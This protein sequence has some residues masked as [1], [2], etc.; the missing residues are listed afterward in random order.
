MASRKPIIVTINGEEHVSH[1]A[2]KASGAMDGFFGKAKGWSTGFANFKAG[3][4]L[5][6]GGVQKFAGAVM[7]TFRAADAFETAQRKLQGTSKLTGISM[8]TL[9]DIAAS[10]KEALKLSTVV[11]NDFASEI[12]K[13]TSKAGDITKSKDAMASFLEIG[14]ARGLSASETLQAVQQAVL[15]IDEGTDKLFGKNP[16]SLYEEYA[17]KVGKSAAKLTDQEKALALVDAAMIGG[18]ATRGS[19][20]SFLDTAA[21]KQDQMNQRIEEAKAQFG[22]ALQPLRLLVMDGIMKLVEWV[23]RPEIAAFAEVIVTIG[24]NLLDS[25]GPAINVLKVV[26]APTL[27]VIMGLLG[28]LSFAVRAYA[29]YWQDSFGKA[30]SSIAGFG[31]SVAGLLKKVGIDVNTEGLDRMKAYGEAQQKEADSRWTALTKEHKEFWGRFRTDAKRG[32]G[33]TLDEVKSASTKQVGAMNERADGV[34]GAAGKITESHKKI[35][36]AA[37]ESSD[38][39]QAAADAYFDKASAKLGKPLALTIGMTEGALRDLS[40]AARE[41]LPPETAEKFAGHMQT[42]A[43]RAE[44][45][46][47]KV[48]AIKTEADGAKGNTKDVADNVKSVAEEALNAAEQFGVVDEAAG[49]SLQSALGIAEAFGRMIANGFT[50]GG[51]VGILGGVA[52]IVG[53]MMQGDRERRELQRESN[54][55]LKD[56]T[57]RVRELTKEVGLLTLDVAGG[58]VASIEAFLEELVPKLARGGSV[59]GGPNSLASIING[60]T[61]QLVGQ[62]LGWDSIVELSK[63]FGINLLDRNGAIDFAQLPALLTALRNTNTAAPAKDFGSQLDILR[64]G[65]AVNSTDDLG[66][67]GQILNLAEQFSPS[68]RGVFRG[69]NLAGTRADLQR[70]FNELAGGRLTEAQLGGLTG[71]QFL[72]LLTDVIGRIDKISPTSATGAES[73]N[74]G[75]PEEA[76]TNPRETTEE[77]AEERAERERRQERKKKLDEIELQTLRAEEAIAVLRRQKMTDEIKKKI[78]HYEAMI[79]SLREEQE[80]WRRRWRIEDITGIHSSFDESEVVDAILPSN[81]GTVTAG[82]ITLPAETIQAVIKTMD[83]NVVTVLTEHTTLHERIAAATEGSYER[84]TSIDAKMDTLIAVTAGQIDTADAR[85]ETL[86]RL[87]MLERGQLPVLR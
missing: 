64:Q 23:S 80:S 67:I 13:L 6:V 30:V 58:E 45:A 26:A 7:D 42:L 37:K 82:G 69:D 52:S 17:A 71:Q 5:V 87:S 60:A 39:S 47:Q 63:K 66:Q 35:G 76:D 73:S 24:R 31:Q 22:T 34:S 33:D 38:I 84:L 53:T 46:R 79:A 40:K 19:Y 36:A 62:G 65:F 72:S 44:D 74:G 85:L 21:G 68:L 28:E 25:L 4:D 51:V 81:V 1:V 55:R 16:S 11:A 59:F 83:A 61:Q 27:T 86:R 20:A 48:L 18:E 49:R 70:L 8:E 56:N 12:G 43:E 75:T 41:Q 14:A 78:D 32:E 9:N 2:Q 57:A 3:W 15:G 54:E 50:F 77:R 10:G 29:S